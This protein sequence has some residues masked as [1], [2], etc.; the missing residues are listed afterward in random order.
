MW[1]AIRWGCENGFREFDFGRSDLAGTGLRQFKDSWGA[2]E[3]PLTYA[4]LGGRRASLA[5][6]S[7]LQDALGTTIR[8]SPSLTCRLLGE[9]LYR[10]AA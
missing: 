6:S 8:H 4:T 10:Y 3:S 2:V 7:R 1:H 5:S 9:L